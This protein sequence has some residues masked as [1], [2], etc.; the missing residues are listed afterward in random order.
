MGAFAEPGTAGPFP[1]RGGAVGK[2]PFSGI[3]VGADLGRKPHEFI[4]SYLS[5]G[6]LP[7]Q[8]PRYTNSRPELYQHPAMTE[9]GIVFIHDY[10]NDQLGVQDTDGG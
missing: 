9:L 7:V 4:I 2:D 3:A 10:R 5:P 6:Q 8:R 1:A